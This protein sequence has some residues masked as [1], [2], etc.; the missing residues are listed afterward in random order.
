MLNISLKY[1][2]F[3][4]TKVYK[5]MHKHL[6]IACCFNSFTKVVLKQTVTHLWIQ[7]CLLGRHTYIRTH[8]RKH[9]HTLTPIP[10]EKGSL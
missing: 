5:T 4:I 2:Y 3:A 10:L 6:K 7:H 9:I 8:V 1:L